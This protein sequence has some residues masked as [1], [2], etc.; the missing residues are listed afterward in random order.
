MS[1]KGNKVP[2]EKALDMTGYGI[3]NWGIFLLSSSIILGMTFEIF[4][5]SYLVPASACELGTSSKQ[6]GLMACVPLVGIIAGSHI[7]GYLADTKGRRK[8]LIIS[9]TLSYIAGTAAAFSNN[10][11]VL[12]LLKLMS[13]ASVSGAFP[14][15]VT[16]LSECT[17]ISKRSS[18]VLLTTSVH[19][20]GIGVMAVVAIPV[21]PL[22]FSYYWP[23]IGIYFNS[24]RFL[25]LIFAVPCAISAIGSYCAFESPK[26]LLS[27]GKEEETLKVLKGIYTMN[28]RKSSDGYEVHSVELDESSSTNYKKGF[29]G[30]IAAQTLP[31]IKAPLLKSTLLVA[32][33]LVICYISMNGFFVWLPFIVNAFM[34]SV[35]GGDRQL[36]IC[37]MI[38]HSANSTV[39]HE[40]NDCSMNSVAMTVVFVINMVLATANIFISSIVNCFGRKRL[41]ITMQVVAGLSALVINFSPYWILSATLLVTFL[42]AILNFGLINTISVDVFPTYVRAM[43]V[44]ATMMVGRASS[45]LSINM[46]KLLL[47]Y[48]CEAVFYIFGTITLGGGAIGLLL[49]SEKKKNN[50]TTTNA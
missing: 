13:S 21:L 49:P 20:A 24:W 41:F 32:T 35:I 44:C 10:W 45:V 33:L 6:Q 19:L 8:V 5:V 36:T 9:M 34:K 50:E 31:L 47:D 40:A 23:A 11:I 12:S 42:S 27:V 38:R 4:S 39:V 2:F 14:L 43:A 37:Q 1:G 25:D 28:T 46:I 22:T 18:L 30:S 16:L 7:W 3:Y 48:N 29:W 15:S 17:P 26:Y